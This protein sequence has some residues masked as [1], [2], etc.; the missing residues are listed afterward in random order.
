MDRDIGKTAFAGPRSVTIHLRKNVKYNVFSKNLFPSRTN[1][2]ILLSD[3]SEKKNFL[4][5]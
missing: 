4:H 2:N 3:F 5:Y 1:K